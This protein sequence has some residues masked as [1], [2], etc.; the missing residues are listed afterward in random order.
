MAKPSHRCPDCHE[1]FY[2]DFQVETHRIERQ[3]ECFFRRPLWKQNKIR[4]YRRFHGIKVPPIPYAEDEF[5]LLED[6][7]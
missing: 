7:K 3:G 5:D 4:Q 2:S 1:G 6:P